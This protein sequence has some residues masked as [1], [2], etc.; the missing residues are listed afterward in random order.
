MVK[1]LISVVNYQTLPPN[2]L[3]KYI[4]A[5]A[6]TAGLDLIV[7]SCKTIIVALLTVVIIIKCVRHVRRM[8]YLLCL[9]FV[10]RNWQHK[11]SNFVI[12]IVYFRTLKSR[13]QIFYSEIPQMTTFLTFFFVLKNIYVN[14]TDTF[15]Y[16]DL[17]KTIFFF[18][19]KI[20][21]VL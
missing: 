12:R 6:I 4:T 11:I 16:L 3:P 21:C 2:K 8:F 9:E 5:Y 13:I 14:P 7:F 20:I 15:F 18:N 1:P 17:T 10:F 19:S